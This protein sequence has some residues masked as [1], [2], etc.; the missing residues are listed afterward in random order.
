MRLCRGSFAQAFLSDLKGISGILWDSLDFRNSKSR[1]DFGKRPRKGGMDLEG[2]E[3]PTPRVQSGYSS[4]ELQAHSVPRGA[5]P[6]GTNPHPWWIRV[7]RWESH[8]PG[9]EGAGSFAQAFLSDSQRSGQEKVGVNP[10]LALCL[11]RSY[12]NSL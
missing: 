3:P 7:I 4:T 2:F 12:E 9:A 10:Q 1:S 5:S 11:F 8:P 6:P